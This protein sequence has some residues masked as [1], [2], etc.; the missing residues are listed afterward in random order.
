VEF[1]DKFF[2]RSDCLSQ[3]RVIVMNEE[4]RKRFP[5]G[6]FPA[7]QTVQV[8]MDYRVEISAIAYI[9]DAER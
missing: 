8:G 9:P 3:A 1:P 2:A 6:V 5:N 4:Y 7:R